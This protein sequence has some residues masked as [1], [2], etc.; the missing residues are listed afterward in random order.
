M[1]YQRVFLLKWQFW[2]GSRYPSGKPRWCFRVVNSYWL[3]LKNRLLQEWGIPRY[4]QKCQFAK[5]IMNHPIVLGFPWNFSDT[6]I[7]FQWKTRVFSIRIGAV[8]HW[9]RADHM[10]RLYGTKCHGKGALGSQ[11]TGGKR[12]DLWGFLMWLTCISRYNQLISEW[13]ITITTVYIYIYMIYD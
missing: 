4:T 2:G 11:D 9:W 7:K 12:A 8:L 10:Q 13:N 5:M 3:E 6:K 1:V